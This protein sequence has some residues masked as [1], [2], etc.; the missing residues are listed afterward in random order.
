MQDHPRRDWLQ[1]L[2]G[3]V[4]DQAGQ[5]AAEPGARRFQRIRRFGWWGFGWL[6]TPGGWMGFGLG[7]LVVAG[8]VMGGWGLIRRCRCRCRGWTAGLRV[9][10]EQHDQI[11]GAGEPAGRFGPSYRDGI[12]VAVEEH[13]LGDAVDQGVQQDLVAGVGFDH[14]GPEPV[15]GLGQPHLAVELRRFQIGSVQVGV[16]VHDGGGQDLLQSGPRQAPGRFACEF[17]VDGGGRGLGQVPAGFADPA[18]EP[19]PDPQVADS[20]PQAGEAV[21]QIEGVDDQVGRFER[22]RA[23]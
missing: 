11:F 21:S 23:P 5:I 16:G 3:Q 19:D 2:G 20:P 8:V 6:V 15:L 18:G 14:H 10:V 12:G 9:P 4:V 7:V 17:G 1:S 22:R 13:D